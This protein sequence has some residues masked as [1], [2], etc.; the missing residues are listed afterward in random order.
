MNKTIKDLY[1]FINR[2]ERSRK[3]PPATAMSLKASLRLFEAELNEDE[4]NSIDLFEKNFDQIYHSVTVKNGT[5][6]SS[7]SLVTYKSRVKK[8]LK[9]FTTLSTNQKR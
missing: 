5:S 6:M 8:V 3:Y 1:A 7:N 2:A 4:K 9:H